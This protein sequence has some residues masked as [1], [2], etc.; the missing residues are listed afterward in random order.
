MSPNPDEIEGVK[1]YRTYIANAWKRVHATRPFS[2]YLILALFA[3]LPLGTVMIQSRDDPR[4]FALFLTLH[5]I[6]LFV[7]IVQAAFD[8]VEIAK[9]HFKEREKLYRTT[10]GDREFAEELGRRV[11]ERRREP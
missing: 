11:S 7:L 5:L 8:L 4:R 9:N 1:S 6:F 2:F 10:L 3:M